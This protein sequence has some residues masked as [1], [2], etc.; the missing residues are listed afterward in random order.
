MPLYFF[1]L[2]ECGTVI[3]DPEGSDLPDLDAAR[4]QAEMEAR[5]IMSAEI[6]QGMLCL[7]C[8]IVI[9]D[10]D[11]VEVARMPFRDAVS[12]SGLQAE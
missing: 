2:N 3:A 11:D 12:I 9:H 7:G 10:A 1:H 5:Q 8:C 6:R 4:K